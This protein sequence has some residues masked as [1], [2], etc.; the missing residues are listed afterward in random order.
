M[1]N[2]KPLYLMNEKGLSDLELKAVQDGIIELMDCANIKLDIKNFGVWRANISKPWW[3]IDW[4]LEQGKRTSTQNNQINAGYMLDLII[5]EPWRKNEDHYDVMVLHSDIYS[6][7]TRF[8]IGLAS[9]GIGTIISVKRFKHSELGNEMKYE[10][11]KTETMH[12]L[13]HVFGLVP[14]KRKINVEESLGK[15]CTNRCVMRQGLTVPR[16]WIN[17]TK[18]RLKYKPL[19]EICETD[20]KAYFRK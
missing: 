8:V 19:C 16:D 10:C 14:N 11:I 15:H 2:I 20:L 3:S 12:E 17:I 18:D 4:Y 5:Q 1:N 13:G 7:D 6:R 9:E